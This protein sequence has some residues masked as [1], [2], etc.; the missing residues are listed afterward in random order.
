MASGHQ[1]VG[2]AFAGLLCLCALHNHVSIL[3]SRLVS[4]SLLET[5]VIHILKFQV[6]KCLK[7]LQVLRYRSQSMRS[8][9]SEMPL[10]GAHT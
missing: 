4:Y 2:T 1:E 10:D 9:K 8:I 5:T 7:H 6:N 3:L